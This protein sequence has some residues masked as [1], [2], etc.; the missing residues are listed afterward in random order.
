[1]AEENDKQVKS[2]QLVS[3]S[4]YIGGLWRLGGLPLVLIGIGAVNIF[5]PEFPGY[6]ATEHLIVTAFTFISGVITWAVTVFLA[7]NRWKAE[8]NI[9]GQRERQLIQ[10]ICDLVKHVEADAAVQFRIN[11]LTDAIANIETQ[12]V[13]LL[14][15]LDTSAPHQ[16]KDVPGEQKG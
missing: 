1:M 15:S 2:D 6:D 11:I 10:S 13:Q 9:A 7:Y 4:N 14:N 16:A 8:L 5:V 12:K 3:L